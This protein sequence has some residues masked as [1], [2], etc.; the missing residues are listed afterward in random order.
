MALQTI[1]ATTS[2]PAIEIRP[3]DPVMG[4]EVLGADVSGPVDASQLRRFKRA[5]DRYKVLVFRDQT[6]TK[7]Q[8]VD[9]SR[10]W[11][12]LGEHIMPGATQEDMPEVAVA[13]N[14]GPDGK[15]NGRH[16][17][18]SAKRW[19]TDRSYMP[20]PAL[21]TLLYG[22]EVPAIGGDT[23]F[24]NATM[25]YAALPEDVRQRIDR[26]NA[27]HWV[28]HSRRT[29]GVALA[30]EYELSRAPPV[31]H[32]LAR[33]HPATGEKSIYCGCHAWKVD[34]L[35]DD[36]GRALLDYLIGFAVQER[37]VYRHQW[38]RHDLVMWDNRCTFHAAT[39]YDTTKEL[40]IMHRTILE[41]DGTELA[42]A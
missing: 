21:A 22:L 29:G 40:R 36:E 30:T 39:D 41:G 34:G 32:P 35:P 28:E 12:E 9:F 18:P 5:L 24:A 11:G 19:H 8:L 20:R 7:Q 16:P 26:L 38:K 42:V 31:K 6:L 10:L 25:A 2:G 4:A 37:F 17:D 33:K 27:I 14:A 1:D 3:L 13:S 23:L 15:P